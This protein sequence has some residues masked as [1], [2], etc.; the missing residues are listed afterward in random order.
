MDEKHPDP[1]QDPYQITLHSWDKVS[2]SGARN[3]NPATKPAAPAIGCMCTT[4][5]KPA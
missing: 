4:T 3:P 2:P 5:P 1:G